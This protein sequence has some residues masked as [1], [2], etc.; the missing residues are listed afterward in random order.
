MARLSIALLFVGFLALSGCDRSTTVTGPNGEKVTVSKDGKNVVVTGADNKEQKM[1]VSQDG[2]GVEISGVGPNGEKVQISQGAGAS[3]P[4]DFPSDVPVYAGAKPVMN[5][6]VQ[7]GT[8]V[9]LETTDPSDKVVE[10]YDKNLK[11]Q[12]WE[13]E[14]K[15]NM[16]NT[17]SISSKKEKRRLAVNIMGADNKT[18]IQLVLVN[19]K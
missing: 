14:S 17:V 4:K 3:L 7:E 10:Y 16:Q 19:E 6:T 1:T 15:F 9:M 11:E 12:G 18:T 2:K 13:Q 5:A 8:T